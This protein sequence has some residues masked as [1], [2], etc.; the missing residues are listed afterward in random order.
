MAIIRLPHILHLRKVSRLFAVLLSLGFTCLGKNKL[1]SCALTL[2][3]KC[4]GLLIDVVPGSFIYTA[5]RVLVYRPSCCYVSH[6]TFHR[7]TRPT[8]T[9]AREV[10]PY[11]GLCNYFTAIDSS[12]A[13]YRLIV[14]TIFDLSRCPVAGIS[15][16]FSDTHQGI[17]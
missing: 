2:V 9:F 1:T 5:D 7:Q 15:Y 8:A 11:L 3:R 12:F 6:A 10:K 16:Q 14:I 4:S 17:Y 13:R